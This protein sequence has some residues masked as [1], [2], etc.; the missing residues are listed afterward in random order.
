M[1]EIEIEVTTAPAV[2]EVELTTGAPGLQGAT[3]ATGATGPQGIQGLQG[4]QGVQGPQGPQGATGA[5]GASTWDSVTGKPTTFTPASHTH[6]LSDISQSSATSGQVPSWNGTAWVPTTPSGGGSSQVNSDWNATSGLAQILN[7]PDLA[8]LP[9]QQVNDTSSPF[10]EDLYIAGTYYAGSAVELNATGLLLESTAIGAL[11]NVQRRNRIM[12]EGV[13]LF[14]GS[15]SGS[16]WNKLAFAS[17]DNSFSVGQAITAAANTS[18]LTASYSVTGTNTTPLLNLSGTWNTTGVARGILLN[19]TDTSSAG[20]SR[21]LELQT[22]GTSR[23][24]VRKDGV[25]SLGID[26]QSPTGLAFSTGGLGNAI[27]TSVN[28]AAHFLVAASR[29]NLPAASVF[30]WVS[31]TGLQGAADTIL[32]RDAAN[33]LA[34]RNGTNAQAFRLYNTFTDASNFERGFMRWNSNTLEIGTEAGGTGTARTTSI[35]SAG[36]ITLS[37][38]GS[39]KVSIGSSGAVVLAT[40]QIVQG[41]AGGSNFSSASDPTTATIPSGYWAIYRNT[42]TGVISLW[43]NNAGSMV[44]ISLA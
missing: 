26:H 38:A 44:K 17:L 37:T 23:F 18:A 10:F 43:S 7:K 5:D 2:L 30:G 39:Q 9:N 22:G 20:A 19:I 31:G 8:N 11:N 29:V 25:I 42:T 4:I 6:P 27:Q 34:Q 21:L 3:G 35:I 16:S 40:T 24:V 13:D 28:G 32:T 41:V 33:T 12:R 15:A 1:A 36:T 14:Y